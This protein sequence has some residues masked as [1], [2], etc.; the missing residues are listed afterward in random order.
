M[1][2][3]PKVSDSQV[4]LT[5]AQMANYILYPRPYTISST[6]RATTIRRRKSLLWIL[7]YL[8]VVRLAGLLVCTSSRKSKLSHP[9]TIAESHTHSRHRKLMSPAFTV[10]QLRSFLPLFQEGAAKVHLFRAHDVPA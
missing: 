6:S 1:V 4:L 5:V 9:D 10:P 7:S 8:L 2:T 3:D